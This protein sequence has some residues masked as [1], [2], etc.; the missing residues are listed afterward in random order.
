MAE[1]HE[2]NEKYH[3]RKENYEKIQH[4][5][6]KE[7]KKKSSLNISA[8]VFAILFVLAI[9]YICYDNFGV[10]FGVVEK[11]TDLLLLKNASFNEGFNS[12]IQKSVDVILSDLNTN[13]YTAVT[14]LDKYKNQTTIPLYTEQSL[15]SAIVVQLNQNQKFTFVTLD[16]NNQTVTVDLILPQMCSSYQANKAEN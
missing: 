8:I 2:I 13:G 3:E 1:F 9:G 4:V 5:G 16:Q 14:Y 11:E 15:I 7:K 12:G 6:H 10:T